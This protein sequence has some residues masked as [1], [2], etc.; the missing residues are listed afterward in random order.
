[1]TAEGGTGIVHQAPAFGEDD[2]RVC[3]KHGVIDKGN[4]VPCPVDFNGC[5]TSE[6]ARRATLSSTV[7]AWFLRTG[8][9]VA[10]GLRRARSESASD[11]VP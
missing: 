9:Q 7:F 1:V 5:F 10:V 11:T 6:V 8:L 4:N 2:Y 3:L